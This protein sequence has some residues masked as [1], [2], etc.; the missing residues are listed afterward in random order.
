[1]DLPLRIAYGLYLAWLVAGAGDFLCHRRTD[2]P[3]TSGVAES[4][5]HLLQLMILGVA[6]LV[7]LAFRI[8]QGV[9]LLLLLLVATH[10]IVGYVDTRIAFGRGRVISPIEQHLHSVL[11]MAPIVSLMAV[12]A[13]T[14]PAAVSGGVHMTLRDPPLPGAIWLAVLLPAGVLC[15]LPALLEIKAALAQSR[16]RRARR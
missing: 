2:L 3:H 6:I 4:I 15:V 7:G 9:A 5:T 8:G 12:V 16:R 10:A 11:D 1:M 14:W 13:A